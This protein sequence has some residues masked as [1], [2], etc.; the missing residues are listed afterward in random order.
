MYYGSLN[1]SWEPKLVVCL[2]PH[3]FKE[4]VKKLFFR[5]G[6]RK[7]ST[8]QAPVLIPRSNRPC[9]RPCWYWSARPLDMLAVSPRGCGPPKK[10]TSRG[11]WR[12]PRAT[13]KERNPGLNSQIIG[14]RGVVSIGII[15]FLRAIVIETPPWLVTKSTVD[16]SCASCFFQLLID[17]AATPYL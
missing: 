15:L 13:Q 14:T 17:L 12:E 2:L 6:S 5:F 8:A 4:T 11:M 3:F 1:F 10:H 9:N 16:F 7:P